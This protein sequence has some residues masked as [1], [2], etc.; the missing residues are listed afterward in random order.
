M[1][2]LREII[3]GDKIITKG[4]LQIEL[5][6]FYLKIL[7]Y[8]SRIITYFNNLTNG[9]VIRYNTEN[10]M[11]ENKKLYDPQ[12]TQLYEATPVDNLVTLFSDVS[13][14]AMDEWLQTISQYDA[15]HFRLIGLEFAGD[16]VSGYN[17]AYNIH[18]DFEL[19]KLDM[20]RL[21]NLLE[22]KGDAL[23][24]VVVQSEV[25]TNTNATIDTFGAIRFVNVQ[26]CLSEFQE[27]QLGNHSIFTVGIAPFTAQTEA[28]RLYVYGVKY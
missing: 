19:N 28:V 17:G 7:P 9:D 23:R 20:Q 13:E 8:L 2:T 25:F 27:Q 10:E 21:Q 18:N 24:N 14:S 1:N 15:L 22:F 4:R 11:W 3:G 6:N 16:I 5:H 26:K 12:Y